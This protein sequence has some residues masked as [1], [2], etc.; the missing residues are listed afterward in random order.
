MWLIL[1]KSKDQNQKRW[2]KPIVWS[3]SR[4]ELGYQSSIKCLL[5][6]IGIQLV[7]FQLRAQLSIA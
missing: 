7:S 4:L 3:L 5:A 6:D 1:S 2:D